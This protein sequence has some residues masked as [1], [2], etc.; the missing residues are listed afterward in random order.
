MNI[1]A[2]RRIPSESYC[3][4]INL[5]GGFQSK[6]G[7]NGSKKAERELANAQFHLAGRKMNDGAVQ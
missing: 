6:Q 3:G 4:N 7:F 1:G 2:R 5:G